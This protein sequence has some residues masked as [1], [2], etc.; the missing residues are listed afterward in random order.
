[1]TQDKE[2]RFQRAVFKLGKRKP[3]SCREATNTS[4]RA[5]SS[6]LL[7]LDRGCS[8]A[9]DPGTE[10]HI[11]TMETYGCVTT[12]TKLGRGDMLSGGLSVG[13][14]KSSSPWLAKAC[15]RRRSCSHEWEQ[16]GCVL[17]ER[18]CRAGS[19]PRR[20]RPPSRPQKRAHGVKDDDSS[21]RRVLSIDD[22]PSNCRIFSILRVCVIAAV[23]T[24]SAHNSQVLT[25]AMIGQK[26]LA[27]H[28]TD[29][30]M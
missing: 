10:A 4:D 20:S 28:S 12:T 25:R 26:F 8:R 7:P 27:R 6:S 9:R 29:T 19:P 13:V 15:T 1:M 16:D 11:A 17:R 23:C 21:H 22:G 5:S 3:E 2:K 14:L 30:D 18:A 24:C